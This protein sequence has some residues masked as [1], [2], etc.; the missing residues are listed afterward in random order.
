MSIEKIIPKE[1]LGLWVLVN[2]SLHDLQ[3]LPTGDTAILIFLGLRVF[4][5][6]DAL[7]KD[8]DPQLVFTLRTAI[9]FPTLADSFRPVS[10]FYS[11]PQQYNGVFET[12]MRLHFRGFQDNPMTWIGI[13]WKKLTA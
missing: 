4:L 7:T 9:A 1:G 13:P 3:L 5:G 2:N 11:F 10:M 12:I 6:Y 8:G